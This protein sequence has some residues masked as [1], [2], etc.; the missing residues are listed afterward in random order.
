MMA[1][2]IDGTGGRA[3]VYVGA[4]TGFGPNGR[5]KADGI[6]VFELD[7]STG[8]L[9][10]VQTVGGIENPTFL[11]LHP[12]RRFVYAVN[13]SPSPGGGVTALE[14]DPPS[15]RLR[16]IGWQ[17]TVG[18]GPCHAT[19]DRTGRFVLAACYHTGTVWVFPTRTDGGLDPVREVV[20]H[21]G[22]SV[23]PVRQTSPHPHSVN[24]DAAERYLLVPDLGLDRVMVYR[25]DHEAGHLTPN[26]PP[27]SV[28]EPGSGPRHLAFHPSGRFAFVVNEIASTL[29]SF[30]FDPNTGRLKALETLPTVPAGYVGE[31]FAA[32]VQPG[33][34]AARPRVVV[35]N[36]AAD[37]HVAPSGRFVYVSNRGHDS[38]VAY[39]FD[40]ELE[41]L[42]SVEQVGTGGRVPRGF[43][44]AAAGR[45][46]IAANQGSDSVFTFRVDTKSGRVTP[47]GFSATSPTPTNALVVEL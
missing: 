2:G 6:D 42:S 38:I 31:P 14:I 26:D 13:G 40:A 18:Q 4:Y 25:F 29:T 1:A 5:G 20:T 35:G 21:L 41:R 19:V 22:S 17:P 39:A 16:P 10:H 47:T 12:S 15:G 30:R 33:E 44:L 11:A 46:L 34:S 3:L 43:A 28:V 23:H 32:D 36:A 8:A 27:W 37:V 24:F 45:L 7:S 9:A